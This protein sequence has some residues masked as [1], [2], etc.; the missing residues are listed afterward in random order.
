MKL[1]SS[2]H[3][4]IQQPGMTHPLTALQPRRKGRN[5]RLSPINACNPLWTHTATATTYNIS[6]LQQTNLRSQQTQ[7]I[8]PNWNLL[9]TQQR[10]R[11]PQPFSHPIPLHRIL[12]ADPNASVA[13]P[14]IFTTSQHTYSFNLKTLP[15]R[16]PRITSPSSRLISIRIG[17]LLCK[18]RSIRSTTTTYG[19]SFHFPPTKRPS[20]PAGFIS[21]KHVSTSISQDSR[22]A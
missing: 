16:T 18:Q 13:S 6:Q 4:N 17:E 3:T 1:P 14:G 2:K 11:T 9:P 19:L 8:L 22:T 21:S 7:I 15:R 10:P 5:Y 20:P 12:S